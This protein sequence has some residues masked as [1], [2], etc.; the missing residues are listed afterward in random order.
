MQPSGVRNG[1][2]ASGIQTRNL[3]RA[4]RLADRIN[5][6]TVWIYTWHKYHPNGPFGGCKMSGY[7]REQAAEALESYTQYKSIWANIA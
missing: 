3:G 2:L 5:A 7:G 6:G 1:G 4:L